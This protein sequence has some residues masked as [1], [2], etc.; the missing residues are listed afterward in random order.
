MNIDL[1]KENRSPSRGSKPAADSLRNNSTLSRA[2]TFVVVAV[3]I[4]QTYRLV[5]LIPTYARMFDDLGSKL[6]TLAAL[7]IGFP[8]WG[9]WLLTGVICL[10]LVFK[11]R[12][13]TDP[14]TRFLINFI[15]LMLLGFVY[16]IIASSL[17]DPITDLMQVID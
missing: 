10:V 1:Q 7:I 11:D 14:M 8:L 9:Y 13:F 5:Q 17:A 4:F 16:A 12:I 15:T 6:G 3:I 2:V